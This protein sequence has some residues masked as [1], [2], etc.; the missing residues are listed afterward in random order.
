MSNLDVTVPSLGESITEA[1][2][3]KWLKKEG[4]KVNKDEVIA[5][6]ETDKVTQEIYSPKTGIIKKIFFSGGRRG[7]NWRNS[8]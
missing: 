2:I 1:I 5:E 4:E 8:R 6:L 7:K 3:A